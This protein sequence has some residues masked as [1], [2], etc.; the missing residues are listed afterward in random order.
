[1]FFTISKLLWLFADPF[2]FIVI[3]GVI[4][5]ALSFLGWAPIGKNICLATVLLLAIAC[6]TPLG[7]VLLRPLEDRFPPPPAN[8]PAP[9]GIIVLGGALDQDMTL[10]R[11]QPTLTALAARLTTGVA[12]ARRFP[13]ARLIFTGGAG[14]LSA[15]EPPEAYG[16]RDLW[17]SLGVPEQRMSFESKSRNTWENAINTRA[18]INPKPDETWLL[19]TSA[20]H[21]PRA[22]GIFRR[23]GFK[24]VAYPVDYRTFGDSRDFLLARMGLDQIMMLEYAVHEWIGLVA[25]HL[26]GKTDAWF[27]AP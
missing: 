15:D 5:L 4:G 3:L 9:A 22:V 27:P 19:V 10:A 14:G 21:V 8:L 7:S 12:L 17:L 6:F 18:L 13:Q 26:T 24:V 11:K 20:W 16:V 1:M 25:Y 23:A 2:S